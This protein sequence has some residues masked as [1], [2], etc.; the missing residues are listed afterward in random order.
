MA[1]NAREDV[2]AKAVAAN[3]SRGS[4]NLSKPMDGIA[5][6]DF[7]LARNILDL[8]Q[9]FYTEPRIINVVSNRM[10][11]DN[12]QVKVNQPDPETGEILLD[13]TMGEYD[14]VVSSTPHRET[15][16]DSQFEQATAL[17]ELGVQIPDEVL[18]ANS[19]LNKRSEIIQQMRDAAQ[20]P[21]AQYK[22]QIQKMQAELEL[23][24]VKAESAKL[25][26][27]AGLKTSKMQETQAKTATEMRGDPNEGAKLQLEM[28]VKQQEAGLEMQKMQ[29]ELLFMRE[30]M[31]LKM[32]EM[33]AKIQATQAEAAVKLRATLAESAAKVHATQAQSAA[34][35]QASH[36]QAAVQTDA[37]DKQIEQ[38]G[39]KHKQGMEQAKEGHKL[40]LQT[41]QAQAKAKRDAARKPV[42]K[43]KT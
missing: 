7:I 8:V 28:Q 22:A 35:V 42:T 10:T 21:D 9:M 11:G 4:L 26:A 15:L 41:M 30:E 18:I 23:A 36:A 32:Q 16:E 38:Q 1:G 19:R 17:K 37:A 31:E 20:S 14:V 5:R 27:D 6:T 39:I 2:S 13:L 33:Q 40:K 12:E 3:T 25:E 24:K 43:A 34:K 29:A